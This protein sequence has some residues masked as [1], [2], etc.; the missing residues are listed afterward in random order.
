MSNLTLGMWLSWPL[1]T[2]LLVAT[3]IAYCIWPLNN[4]N[5]SEGGIAMRSLIAITLLIWAVIT[6]LKS[7][8]L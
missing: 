2:V 8:A 5:V 3:V 6:L 1:G 4:K 7:C